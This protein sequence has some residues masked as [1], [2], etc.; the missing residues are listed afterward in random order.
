MWINSQILTL[1]TNIDKYN[2]DKYVSDKYRIARY[3]FYYDHH[4]YQKY[5]II[6]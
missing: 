6:I 1:T 4:R 2:N 3:I 5:Y